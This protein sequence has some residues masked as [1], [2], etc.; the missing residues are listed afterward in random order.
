MGA[1]ELILGVYT[2]S[3]DVDDPRTGIVSVDLFFYWCI[4]ILKFKIFSLLQFVP[5][6]A[7]VSDIR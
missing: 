6:E 5:G 1:N 3:L 2:G 7:N 4:L